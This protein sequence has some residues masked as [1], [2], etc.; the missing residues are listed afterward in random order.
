MV[1][2]IEKARLYRGRGGEFVRGAAARLLQAVAIAH[3]PLT[4]KMQV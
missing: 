2:A 4:V 1:P 3:I